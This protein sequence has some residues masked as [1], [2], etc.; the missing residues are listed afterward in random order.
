MTL[1]EIEQL[2]R[3]LIYEENRTA[4]NN[5]EVRCLLFMG[6]LSAKYIKDPNAQ[7]WQDLNEFKAAMTIVAK[8]H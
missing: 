7:L 1:G 6:W 4:K 3:W 5:D 8:T 2:C